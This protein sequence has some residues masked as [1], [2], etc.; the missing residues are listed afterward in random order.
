MGESDARTPSIRPYAGQHLGQARHTFR[1]QRLGMQQPRQRRDRSNSSSRPEMSSP[2]ARPDGTAASTTR[3]THHMR[4]ICLVQIRRRMRPAR[5]QLEH[6]RCQPQRRDGTRDLP[7]PIGQLAERR[8]HKHTRRRRSAA[9]MTTSS[10]CRSI[11]DGLLRGPTMQV[12]TSCHPLRRSVS[13]E[14]ANDSHTGQVAG[15][16]KQPATTWK[17]NVF[18]AHRGRHRAVRRPY[19]LDRS[20]PG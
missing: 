9:R 4:Q 10:G 7:R 14:P 3:R 15:N 13:E 12:L 8:A 5:P 20:Q 11:P 2:G 16:T 19:P 1:S 6:H 17:S 18:A